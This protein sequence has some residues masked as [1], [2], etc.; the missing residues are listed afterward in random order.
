MILNKSNILWHKLPSVLKQTVAREWETLPSPVSYGAN[1]SIPWNNT[2]CPVWLLCLVYS[3][4][5]HAT[6]SQLFLSV[7]SL[8]LAA[9]AMPSII[10]VLYLKQ[11]VRK[12]CFDNVDE[13]GKVKCVYTCKL[14]VSSKAEVIG[15][16]FAF[17]SLKLVC[18]PHW[19]RP[20]TGIWSSF[21]DQPLK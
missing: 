19:D 16:V 6:S 13:Q 18:R 10:E 21:L 9:H 2:V 7:W 15:E 20:S 8:S 3:V 1:T 14:W 4:W 5:L 17:F 11:S 12:V